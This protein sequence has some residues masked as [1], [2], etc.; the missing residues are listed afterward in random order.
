MNA[1]K[2]AYSFF[3]TFAVI[4]AFCGAPGA[5]FVPAAAF[6]QMESGTTGKDPLALFDQ[7]NRAMRG[8]DYENAAGL[9]ITICKSHP[10]SQIAPQATYYLGRVL[11]KLGRDAEALEVWDS[12]ASKNQFIG[13][14]AELFRL[15][16]QFNIIDK[17]LADFKAKV[18]K[19]PGNYNA[20]M[21]YIDFLIYVNRPDEAVAQYKELMAK[22][23]GDYYLNKNIADLYVRFQRYSDAITYYEK[24][25]E[26]DPLNE[27]FL[28][29]L[30][31][32]HY[33]LGNKKKAGECWNRMI[34]NTM[35]WSKY[36]FLAGVYQSHNMF[37]EAIDVYL[38]C[39]KMSQ[40][41]SLYFV[42][43]AELYEISG[44]FESLLKLYFAVAANSPS[45]VA[46]IESRLA[47]TIKRNN[48]A[49]AP[50]CALVTEKLASV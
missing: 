21:E 33:Q 16:Q 38:K 14:K 37:R 45:S 31:N 49:P 13:N 30:G 35:E 26:R 7:A 5:P 17:K 24:L 25:V 40:S 22:N 42:E 6:A 28:E 34:E 3:I 27:I 20:R 47:E 44:D 32:C 18:E 12:Y 43:L 8:G 1:R 50:L 19:S 39:Q 48:E 46:V 36:N 29:G 2:S 41:P 15:Y 23:N 4:G 10:D 9:L 11:L